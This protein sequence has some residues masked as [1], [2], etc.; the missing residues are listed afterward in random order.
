MAQQG[1]GLQ[2]T[3]FPGLRQRV[4]HGKDGQLRQG[5][6]LVVAQGRFG[7]IGKEN[8]SQVLRHIEKLNQID[9]N[10]MD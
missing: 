6:A 3:G 8:I 10:C 1:K 9:M 2:A 7:A 4:L 5:G